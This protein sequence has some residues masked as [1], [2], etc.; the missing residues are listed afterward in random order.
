MR[1]QFLPL[2]DSVVIIIGL[3]DRKYMLWSPFCEDNN[4]NIGIAWRNGDLFVLSNCKHIK[5]DT[6]SGRWCHRLEISIR[7]CSY[8][9]VLWHAEV[10]GFCSKGP[11]A[12]K[13]SITCL[14]NYAFCES[15]F[16]TSQKILFPF[17]LNDGIHPQ[18]IFFLQHDVYSL[19]AKFPRVQHSYKI[20]IWNGLHQTLVSFS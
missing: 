5:E 13:P 17:Y 14:I 8:F 3:S 6:G 2:L 12:M 4:M 20:L 18:A 15:I 10:S 1:C 11:F 16:L 9:R 19:Y 7:S